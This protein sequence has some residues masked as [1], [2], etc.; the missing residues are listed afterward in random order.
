M[1]GSE[2][3]TWY[4]NWENQY[5]KSIIFANKIYVPSIIKTKQKQ[6]PKPKNP[7]HKYRNNLPCPSIQMDYLVL[8]I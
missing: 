4:S 5:L 3:I 6:I 1:E 2:F 7:S 8:K